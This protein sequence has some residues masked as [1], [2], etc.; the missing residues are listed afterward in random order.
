MLLRVFAVTDTSE[1]G[2]ACL[3]WCKF[4]LALDEPMRIASAA[5]AAE[6]MADRRGNSANPWAELRDYFA[7]PLEDEYVNIVMAPPHW[8]RFWAAKAR[9]NIAIEPRKVSPPLVYQQKFDAV[10]VAWEGE[11][12]EQISC[13]S[14]LAA[15]LERFRAVVLP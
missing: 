10:V 13:I 2:L 6:I 5:G 14:P 4:L 11:D 15:N 3:T 12:T 7:T 1:L 8:D 9:R